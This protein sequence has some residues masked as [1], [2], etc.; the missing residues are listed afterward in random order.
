MGVKGLKRKMLFSNYKLK[1]KKSLTSM[2]RALQKPPLHEEINGFK[3]RMTMKTTVEQ[4]LHRKQRVV[5]YWLSA[6]IIV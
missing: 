5:F 1:E 4:I 3:V 6:A 2:L